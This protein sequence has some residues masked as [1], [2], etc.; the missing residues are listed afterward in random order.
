MEEILVF[1]SP[2]RAAEPHHPPN[3][4]IVGKSP[5]C[6][7]T[8]WGSFSV[9]ILIEQA[10]VSDLSALASILARGDVKEV[11]RMEERPTEV[12]DKED[13]KAAVGKDEAPY[14]VAE[15]I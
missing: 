13:E 10:S 4:S 2:R 9:R 14:Q 8:S 15:T 1:V 6:L 5:K 7:V 12:G 3:R 11:L